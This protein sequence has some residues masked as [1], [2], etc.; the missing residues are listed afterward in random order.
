MTAVA[1]DLG[2]TK[3]LLA[4][5]DHTSAAILSPTPSGDDPEAVVDAI[6]AGI[7]RLPGGSGPVVVASPG[8]LDMVAGVVIEAANLPFRRYPLAAK[9]TE[10]TGRPARVVG[11]NVAGTVAELTTGAG[12]GH[13]NGMYVTVSTGIG[14]GVVRGGRLDW[15]LG[16]GDHELG[17][18]QVDDGPTAERCGCGRRGC[19]E[20]YAS[21][22]GLVRRARGRFDAG[23]EVVEAALSGDQRAVALLRD[24]IRRLAIALAGVVRETGATVLVVG[25]GLTTPARVFES[26]RQE[27]LRALASA[28]AGAEG[29]AAT[30]A[31]VKVVRPAYGARSVLE[32]T[33]ALGRGEA[34]ALVML[35][36][37]WTVNT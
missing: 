20:A 28:S 17:H 30:A 36:E 25:G 18:T 35:G 3:I 31:E 22:A 32:G 1:V 15:R 10:R 7:E 9:L 13:A 33:A 14:L 2:G 19:L 21:G 29:D 6:T 27:V 37:P 4:A 26:V 12:A 23:K 24:G 34:D 16:I 8:R 5:A 11:D